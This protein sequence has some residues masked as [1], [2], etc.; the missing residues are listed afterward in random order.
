MRP[1]PSKNHCKDTPG[2][3]VRY[4]VSLSAQNIRINIPDITARSGRYI[5]PYATVIGRRMPAR[6]PAGPNA[7]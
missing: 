6:D 7:L 5:T 2:I 3:S 4:L 1:I